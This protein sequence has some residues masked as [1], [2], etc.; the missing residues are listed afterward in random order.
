MHCYNE[1][2]A[3]NTKRSAET[4]ILPTTPNVTE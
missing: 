2:D 4:D 1:Y 3:T